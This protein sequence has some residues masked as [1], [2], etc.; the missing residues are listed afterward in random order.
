MY[1]GARRFE[2]LYKSSRR[3]ETLY[4]GSGRLETLYKGVWRDVSVVKVPC[5][6]NIGLEFGSQHL[7]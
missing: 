4:K 6:A 3:L 5:Y 1:K 2:T 7:R